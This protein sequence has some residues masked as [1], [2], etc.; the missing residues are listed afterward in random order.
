[1]MKGCH[2]VLGSEGHEHAVIK[3]DS[4]NLQAMSLYRGLGY[5]VVGELAEERFLAGKAAGD[6]GAW[7]PAL[8]MCMRRSVP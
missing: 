8:N 3:V 5:E 1:M 2:D 7:E 6:P 4:E